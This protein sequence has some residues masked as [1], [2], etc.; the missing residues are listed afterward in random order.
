MKICVKQLAYALVIMIGQCL[1]GTIICYPSPAGNEIRAHHH[2][3]LDSVQWSIYNSISSLFAIS[4]PFVASV[5]LKLFK[6]SRKKTVFVLACFATIFWILNCLTK[7][8]IYLGLITRAL[9]GVVLGSY[10]SI[11]PMYLVEIAPEG[12]NGFF[13][14][15]NQIGII[16]GLLLFDF[17][18]PSLNY[19][20][21]NYLGAALALLQ[22]FLVGWI[23]ESPSV[24]AINTKRKDEDEFDKR[25]RRLFQKKYAFGIAFSIMIMLLQE[26]CGINSI[27]TNLAD[28]MDKS[29]FKIDGN[30]QGGIASCAQLIAVFVSALFIDKI[31][32]KITW[33]ISCSIIVVSLLFFALNTKFEWVN[34][35]PLICIFLYQLGFGLGLGPIPWFIIPEYFNDDLRS[36]ATTIAVAFNWLF[37]FITIL[38]WPYMVTG[39]GMFGS[40][41]FF[42][43]MS[44]AALIFG[45][46]FIHDEKGHKIEDEQTDEKLKPEVMKE[47]AIEV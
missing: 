37:T 26:F 1:Y 11:D 35:L 10:S 39:L 46:I 34:F 2:L 6:N 23:A 22:V 38:I 29:G 16:L 12:L 30:Y 24:E 15:L 4:G 41:I 8:S 25:K 9:L 45:A 28:L 33:I 19:M 3:D 32:R 27:L 7:I 40:L 47:I 14:C 36:K 42:L 31:G 20:E 17:V 5:F 18:G 44:A 21:L 13:G 43:C